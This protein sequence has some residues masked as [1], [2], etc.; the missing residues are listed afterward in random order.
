[1][2]AARLC[3]ASALCRARAVRLG[4]LVCTRAGPWRG[5]QNTQQA[6]STCE[7]LLPPGRG[8]GLGWRGLLTPAGA[9][10]GPPYPCTELGRRAVRRDQLSW[11]QAG[12]SHVPRACPTALAFPPD[13]RAAGASSLSAPLAAPSPAMPPACVETLPKPPPQPRPSG[14]YAPYTCTM[15]G[16][17]WLGHIPPSSCL[18]PSL[19]ARPCSSLPVLQG[20]GLGFEGSVEPRAHLGA[21][22]LHPSSHAG[23]CSNTSS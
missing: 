13:P 2:A 3:A 8:G 18:S 17:S 10:R 14:R 12:R 5:L 22:Q 6:A 20:R 19:M 11:A 23:P 7:F 1:M 16:R 4:T 15:G 21:L 9:G